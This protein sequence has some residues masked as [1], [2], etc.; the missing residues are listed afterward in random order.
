M[1]LCPVFGNQKISFKFAIFW[2]EKLENILTLGLYSLPL[3]E[4]EWHLPKKWGT[5]SPVYYSP[6]DL[7]P[8]FC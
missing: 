4:A 8:L 1:K 2:A 6:L 3:G 5:G 7:L